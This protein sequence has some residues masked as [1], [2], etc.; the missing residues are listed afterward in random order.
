[1][2]MY[3]WLYDAASAVT[4]ASAWVCS[5]GCLLWL[6]DDDGNGSGLLIG[7]VGGVHPTQEKPSPPPP[8]DE[9]ISSIFI[10]TI[11]I[12]VRLTFLTTCRMYGRPLSS[13]IVCVCMYVCVF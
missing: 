1:M 11:T 10:I 4:S 2:G 12:I 13:C 9:L 7:V 8:P 6:V 5:W 3:S